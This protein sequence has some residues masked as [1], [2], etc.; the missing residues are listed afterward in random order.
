[1]PNPQKRTGKEETG[2]P[3]TSKKLPE[4][5]S[6]CGSPEALKA[7]V[8]GGAD[9]VY[10]GGTA[11]NARINARNF[12]REQLRRAVDFCHG[13]GVRLYVTLNTLVND[14]KLPEALDF[15]AFLYEAG[16]DALITADWGLSALIR[17]YFPRFE[18]H[19]STQFSSHNSL[20]A[21]WLKEKGFS[22][23]VC[24]REL[25][26]KDLSLLCENS[27][28][29]IEVFVHGA[30]CASHSGQCLMSSFI[31]G[32]SGNRG[33]C[34]QPCRMS[35]NGSYPLSLKDLCLAN[36]LTE[37]VAM[38]VSSLKIEGRMKSPQYVYRV[39]SCYR[40]LLDEGRNATPAE[41]KA[42]S[43][44]FS[45]SGFTD[46]YFSSQHGNMLGIRRESDKQL[47]RSD[48]A[49]F[50]DRK[51]SLPSIVIR[52]EEGKPPD[53][54]PS[55]EKISCPVQRTARFLSSWQ[56]PD[57]HGLDVCYLPL[58]SFDPKK[59]NGV[60]LPAVITDS[61]LP[62]VRAA[63]KRAYDQGARHALVGNVGHFSLAREAGF[64]L[65]GDFRLNVANSFAPIEEEGLEDV[66]VSCE[67]NLPQI[68][69]LR[70]KKAV[71]VYG[72]IPV[73]LLERSL[74]AK[75]LKDRKGARFPVYSEG[76]R[77]VLYNS[78]V[79]YMGDKKKD[80]NACG[81]RNQHFIFTQ[82]SPEQVREI[83]KAY[84]EGKSA[85]A[86]IRRIR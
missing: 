60:V 49:P 58:F 82:E 75:A 48:N 34:A 44:V 54:L 27:P 53:A 77:D 19:A 62:S 39:T 4:L 57:G 5:L 10:L 83:L 71:V 14:R 42:L 81:A 2:V 79:L 38:G 35:Y 59:A 72:R 28:I 69:D 61:E 63:L 1:M 50:S 33:E 11:F 6:P 37:L 43:A 70:V 85:P 23:M 68:R 64:L 66:I 56:I 46:G 3:K 16:V 31:G 29:E 32:R 15:V 26:K 25:S 45:R 17:R 41:I 22:R 84:D 12:D 73:M 67:L 21:H 47:S 52:R 24:A 36:H 7:A 8:F 86:G 9:A 13:R 30:L 80:L 40:R 51:R 20:S 74:G 55:G 18:L 78:V 76:K 65:H